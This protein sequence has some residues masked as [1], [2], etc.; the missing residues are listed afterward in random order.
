MAYMARYKLV[1][2]LGVAGSGVIIWYICMKYFKTTSV[3]CLDKRLYKDI[4]NN[5]TMVAEH[6]LPELHIKLRD[7]QTSNKYALKDLVKHSIGRFKT[8]KK[9]TKP[10]GIVVGD[11]ECYEVFRD[12]IDPVIKDLHKVTCFTNEKLRFKDCDWKKVK[13]GRIVD[14]NVLSCVLSTSR[15][16][17]GYRFPCSLSDEGRLEIAK[18]LITVFNSL[19][20]NRK[21]KYYYVTS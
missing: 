1:I 3:C 5:N 21:K 17:A 20:G 9:G 6:Y 7:K 16:I 19:P 13:R 18:E 14:K 11:E 2:G 10:T 12:I 8:A 4:T 15:N